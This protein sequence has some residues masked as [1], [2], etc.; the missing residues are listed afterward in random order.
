LSIVSEFLISHS[1]IISYHDDCFLAVVLVGTG[2]TPV[3]LIVSFLILIFYLLW[4]PSLR[5]RT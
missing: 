5:R 4:H 1:D 2:R 3:L